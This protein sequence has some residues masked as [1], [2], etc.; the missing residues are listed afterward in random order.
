MKKSHSLTTGVLM[1]IPRIK[2]INLRLTHNN[3]MLRQ[4]IVLQIGLKE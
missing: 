3:F 2:K 4:L 1:T